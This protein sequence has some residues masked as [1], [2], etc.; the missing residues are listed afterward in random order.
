MINFK[1]GTNSFHIANSVELLSVCE[2]MASSVSGISSYIS[3]LTPLTS[4][5]ITDQIINTITSSKFQALADAEKQKIIQIISPYTVISGTQTSLT[6]VQIQQLKTGL[7][8]VLISQLQQMQTQ[9]QQI[10]NST[11]STQIINTI[12]GPNFQALA[13]TEKQKILQIISQFII[14]PIPQTSLLPKQ[15]QQLK[16]ALGGVAPSYLQQIQTQI[17]QIFNNATTS[18]SITPNPTF[19]SRRESL[20]PNNPLNSA[21]PLKSW[22]WLGYISSPQ[23]IAEELRRMQ[24]LINGPKG[25]A[26]VKAIKE[27]TILKEGEYRDVITR[28]DFFDKLLNGNTDKILNAEK[29]SIAQILEPESGKYGEESIKNLELTFYNITGPN[30]INDI[31]EI[32][33]GDALAELQTQT[34]YK[35]FTD[36]LDKYTQTKFKEGEAGSAEFKSY[37][38]IVDDILKA[39]IKLLKANTSIKE[40]PDFMRDLYNSNIGMPKVTSAMTVR[41]AVKKLDTDQNV[42]EAF[43]NNIPFDFPVGLED[44]KEEIKGAYST[45]IQDLLKGVP[46]TAKAAEERIKKFKDDLTN[47]KI[48]IPCIAKTIN[49]GFRF[50]S[51]TFTLEQAIPYY[52]N[53]YLN[54]SAYKFDKAEEKEIALYLKLLLS[55]SNIRNS[56][57]AGG[58]AGGAGGSGSGVGGGNINI[59]SMILHPIGRLVTTNNN[60]PLAA[61]LNKLTSITNKQAEM[62]SELDKAFEESGIFNYLTGDDVFGYIGAGSTVISFDPG[63]CLAQARVSQLRAQLFSAF[64]FKKVFANTSDVSQG[65]EMDDKEI[66]ELIDG[67]DPLRTVTGITNYQ[68]AQ[69]LKIY[70]DK[71]L[72]PLQDNKMAIFDSFVTT[73]SGIGTQAF[74]GNG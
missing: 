55:V 41:D 24:E 40:Y 47:D 34:E 56:V 48:S 18:G 27:A 20:G 30:L 23:F 16:N 63:I 44:K 15:I 73:V 21:T 70:M 3:G 6:N 22:T 39:F 31:K 62:K 74:K 54:A 43:F 12:T 2:F 25:D 71:L 11:L 9:I 51:N 59:G 58:S 35:S 66:R 68:L 19:G 28:G 7:P 33:E 36:A 65:K 46:N 72:K 8:K 61:V 52:T 45:D 60:K 57:L 29:I 17:E 10:I 64:L 53:L 4:Q 32:V 69:N 50:E 13:D 26:L 37:K 67:G 1:R 49:A 42:S 14:I 38:T 5:E